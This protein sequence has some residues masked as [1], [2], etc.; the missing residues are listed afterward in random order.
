MGMCRDVKT[1]PK[2]PPRL[3]GN[4][5]ALFA[6]A[7]AGIDVMAFFATGV[8][9]VTYFYG[10]MNFS[11][12]ESATAVTNFMGTA[13]L[14]SLFGAFLSDTYLSRFKTCVLFGCI[15]VVGY[16]LLA[17]QAHFRQLRPFPC[18]DVPLSQMNQCESANKGQLAILYAGL[19]LVAIGTSG[20][21]AAAPPLGA[22]QYDEKDPK[23]AA[24]LSSYFNWLMFFLTTGALFGVTFVVWISENQGWDWSFAVCSI[25]VGFSILFLTLGKSL[26]RNNVT[27]GSPL[28]RIMQVFVVALRNRNL[29]LPENEHELHEIQ[30]KEARYDTEILRKTEQFK[31]LDRA[32]INRTD[33]EASTSNAH[34][35]WKLCTVTQVE[36]TKIVVRMLPII[37]ST[38][39][40][41]TCLAQLQTFT[42]QQ[43]TTMDRKIHKFEV[44]GA[45]IPAIP[46]LFMIILIPIYER[47]FIPIARKFTGIPTGIRQLQRIGVGLVLSSL[48]MAVAAIVEK[49]RKSIAIKH[50]M[51]ESA[52]PLPMSVFWLGYQYAIFGLADMFTLVGLLDFFY[53][54]SSSSMKA[55]STAISW[56]SLAIGYYTSSIVVSVVNKVSGG[57]LAN[58]NLNKDKLDYFYWLLAGLSVLNFGFYLLCASWYKYKKVDVNPEDNVPSN[59]VKEGKGKIEMSIV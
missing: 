51:V 36:E 32:A 37:L 1:E 25:V 8:S 11:I 6:Y 19:Y 44:P 21:K 9:L 47:V 33:Q 54:E 46:L 49:H 10:F 48:S 17:V 56:S 4:R 27:K 5:A 43:S 15:E 57:W 52:A 50:N 2:Q 38:V 13:F 55:L 26:Y 24:K 20:V 30:D 42:I 23:Q 40:M 29:R 34:G 28:T 14:L 18:K 45:S 31:F 39:F 58:N 22:D 35:P 7:I 53:S 3:G 12:T 41:N 16:A 59:K